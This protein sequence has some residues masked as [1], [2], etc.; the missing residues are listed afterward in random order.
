[1]QRGQETGESCRVESQEGTTIDGELALSTLFDSGMK[2]K[3][4]QRSLIIGADGAMFSPL[5][6][7]NLRGTLDQTG[8]RFAN[9]QH[10]P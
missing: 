3:C 1:M 5:A 7:L 8:N 9:R 2:R 6:K 10:F 4:F